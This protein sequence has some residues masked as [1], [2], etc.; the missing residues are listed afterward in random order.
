[1]QKAHDSTQNNHSL[2]EHC[3][4]KSTRFLMPVTTLPQ[5]SSCGHALDMS[6]ASFGFVRSSADCVNDV[7]ELRRRLDTDGYLYIPGFFDRALI[8]AARASV[9]DRLAAAGVL[10]PAYPT[11][12]GIARA[13][14]SSNFNAEPARNNAEIQRV[15]Y[16]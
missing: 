14:V 12:D 10:D 4:L 6:E 9:C 15:V 3:L 8:Q 16:G 1:F 5:L 2:P 13:D 11:I 7:A